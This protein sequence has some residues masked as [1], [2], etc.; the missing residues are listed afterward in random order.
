MIFGL[1]LIPLVVSTGAA[2]DASRALIVR[3]RLAEALDA[4]GL[5]VGGATELSEQDM[6]QLAQD[7]FDAN[8]PEDALGVVGTLNFP[9]TNEVIT[10]SA[11]ATVPTST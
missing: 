5:A 1:S 8:Y 9:I 6:E 7:F 11:T 10:M 3:A 2:S 4:A